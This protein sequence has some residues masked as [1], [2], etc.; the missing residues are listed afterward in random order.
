MTEQGAAADNACR[1]GAPGGAGL[2]ARAR[3]PRDPHPL[4]GSVFQSLSWVPEAWRAG[5]PI[6]RLTYGASPAPW[7]LPALHPSPLE[8]QGNR[9]GAGPAPDR[10]GPMNHA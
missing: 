7:R 1:D 2:L 4:K 6:A 3:A 8:R 9:E 5:R 10:K